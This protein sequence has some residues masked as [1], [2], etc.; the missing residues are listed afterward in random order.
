ML[1]KATSFWN[2]TI[3]DNNRIYK[4]YE[5]NKRKNKPYLKDSIYISLLINAGNNNS[6]K[7]NAFGIYISDLLY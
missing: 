2:K 4:K 3:L 7:N 1:P 6:I 5:A